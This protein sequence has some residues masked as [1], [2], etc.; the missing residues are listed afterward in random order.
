MYGT[1]CDDKWTIEEARV[2]CR[3]LGFFDATAA[4]GQ[5]F[6]GEGAGMIL[7][8][9]VACTGTE[10]DIVQCAHGYWMNTD[11]VSAEDAGVVCMPGTNL[12]SVFL[13]TFGA[14]FLLYPIDLKYCRLEQFT[15]TKHKLRHFYKMLVCEYLSIYMGLMYVSYCSFMRYISIF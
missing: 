9:D 2:I 5:A 14:M 12:F 10:T 11:C 8:D 6:F 15:N 1:I 7:L 3:Q 4:Y 13:A